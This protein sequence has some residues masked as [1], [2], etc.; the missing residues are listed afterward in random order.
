MLITID[1]GALELTVD[2][3]GAQMM[4]LKRHGTEYLWQGDSAYWGDRAPILF[5]FI[6]RLT[7]DSYKF[8]GKVY[9]MTI[10]GFANASEFAVAKK[11]ADALVLELCSSEKTRVHYPIDFVLQ[12]IFR[13][14]GDTLYTTYRVENKSDVTMPFG[15]G[16]HPGFKVPVDENERFEDYYLEFSLECQPDRVGFT[17][18]VY[19][20]GHDEAYPLE[21]DKRIDLR[22]DLFDEDAII[23]KNM[24]REVTLRSKASSHSVTVSYP[25]MP[26][27]GIWHWPHT[28]APYVC[29]EPWSSLPSRQDVVEEFTCKSDLVQLEPG[30]VYDNTWTITIG[31]NH[32]D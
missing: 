29:I 4:S 2:T 17:P 19:L 22:H 25:K 3:L 24:A 16:G 30:C 18:A 23:L 7:N 9:P 20:S 6:A 21:A 1:N 28:D 11:S 5:P 15:I 31:G 8:Q 14:E 13:L 10:H 12:V 26:Y 32:H 27:L